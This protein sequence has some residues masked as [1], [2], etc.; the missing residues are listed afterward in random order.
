MKHDIDEIIEYFNTLSEVD[1]SDYS[2]A[3]QPIDIAP[4][5][6][7]DVAEQFP[8]VGKLLKNSKVYRFFIVGPRI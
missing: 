4:R 2:A 7:K 6:R 3:Y 8:E 5:K 1:C